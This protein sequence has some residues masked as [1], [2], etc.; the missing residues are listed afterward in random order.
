M[1]SFGSEHSWVKN[2]HRLACDRRKLFDLLRWINEITQ[3]DLH[4]GTRNVL[5][6][7]SK[8][9][10]S[11]GT[12]CMFRFR[13]YITHAGPITNSLPEIES[14][15]PSFLTKVLPLTLFFS[16][17]THDILVNKYFAEHQRLENVI[18]ES[19]EESHANVFSLLAI[20]R[21]PRCKLSALKVSSSLNSNQIKL[22]T[23]VFGGWWKKVNRNLQS[24]LCHR[25]HA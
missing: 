19:K 24:N 21:S 8:V 10:R 5:P 15:G 6:N 4:L 12:Q 7:L 25:K 18:Q 20:V 1:H 17:Y 16:C 3:M 2:E 9:K 23:P 14:V 11:K 22:K 13:K